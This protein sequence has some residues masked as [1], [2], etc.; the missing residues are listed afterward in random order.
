MLGFPHVDAGDGWLIF[1]LPPTEIAV[2]PNEENDLHEFYLMCD[3]LRSE[4]DRLKAC[5]YTS[6]DVSDQP[7]GALTYIDLPGG[8]KLGLY[9]PKH[10]LAHSL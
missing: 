5:G 10:P 2:H 3:D 7:W 6:S 9:E 1:K 8:G 4:I